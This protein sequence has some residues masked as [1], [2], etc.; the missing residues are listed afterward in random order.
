MPWNLSKIWPMFQ[1]F[2]DLQSKCSIAMGF[3]YISITVKLKQFSHR[4]EQRF[5]IYL[6]TNEY[7]VAIP[8][9]N[10]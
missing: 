1:F 4:E 7:N 10:P 8:D 3:Q 5:L 2:E 9:D 6:T